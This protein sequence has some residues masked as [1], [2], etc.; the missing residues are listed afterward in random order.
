MGQGILWTDLGLADQK[1][2]IEMFMDM[3]RPDK[4]E[5]QWT[6]RR[7]K[8]RQVNKTRIG[9]EAV[10][11]PQQRGDVVGWNQ[12]N[13]GDIEGKNLHAWWSDLSCEKGEKEGK[14]RGKDR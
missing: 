13:S 14:R 6:Y 9:K 4:W 12:Q 2:G 1:R 11:D 3:R 7:W 10:E 8:P 5:A